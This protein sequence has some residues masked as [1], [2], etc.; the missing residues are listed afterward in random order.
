[1]T[2]ILIL[3]M[4]EMLNVGYKEDTL[5]F[6]IQQ[7]ST[8]IALI[9]YEATQLLNF[10]NSEMMEVLLQETVVQTLAL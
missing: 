7:Q 8:V 9:T 3:E 6:T 5:V 10:R 1:M 4:V 2:I